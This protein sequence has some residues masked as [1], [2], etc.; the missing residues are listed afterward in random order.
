M[1]GGPL[2]RPLRMGLGRL[3]IEEC[4]GA[5]PVGFVEAELLF[6]FDVAAEPVGVAPELCALCEAAL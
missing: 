2:A 4:G 1:T 5:M 6:D 3:S